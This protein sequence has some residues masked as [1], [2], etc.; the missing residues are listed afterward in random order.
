MTLHHIGLGPGS[1]RR[2]LELALLCASVGFAVC[3]WRALES[4]EF[5]MPRQSDRILAQFV[6]TI[7]L[8]HLAL[9]VVAPRTSAHL[10]AAAALLS[11]VGLALVTRLEPSVAGDQ[12]NW[13]SAGVLV[14]VLVAALSPLY[15]R[16]HALK[17]TAA[18]AS[19]LLLFAAG[20]FGET[21]NG[22]RLWIIIAGQS[23]QTTELLKVSLL[24]FLSGYLADTA[25]ILASPR[26]RFG[27]RDYSSLPYL[28]PLAVAFLTALMAL[29]LLKDLGSIALL[30]LLALSAL[31]VA[32]GRLRFVLAGAL[33]LVM[34]AVAGYFAFDHVQAR[35]DVWRDPY[36]QADGAGYQTVQSLYAF[37]AG[38]VTGEGLGLGQP[39]SIPAAPTDYVF[40]AAAEELGMAGAAG[41]VALYVVFVVAGFHVTLRATDDFTRLMACCIAMLIGIQATVII[42]GNLRII[43]TTGITLPF[44]SYGGSSLLVNFALTG[45]LLGISNRAEASRIP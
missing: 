31:Y 33:M 27:G 12:A 9:R 45:L 35:V 14:M 10:Y 30:L 37:E 1:S 42:A 44:V 36:A 18:L 34:V 25:G 38:G 7:V 40:A 3:A 32:T 13:I 2:N 26:I 17:Y 29:A 23:V 19:A 20:L 24:V 41:I 43:P 21:I 8:G 15:G 39:D 11:A 28:I 16:L 22:A 6:T 4:A 5:A